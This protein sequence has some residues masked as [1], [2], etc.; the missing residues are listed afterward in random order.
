MS[1]TIS[2]KRAKWQ[3]TV[4]KLE[5]QLDKL[6]DAILAATTEY[7]QYKLETGEGSQSVKYRDLGKLIENQT[8]LQKQ[9]DW[10]NTKICGGGIRRFS[11][12]RRLY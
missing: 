4:T 7:E 5:A 8:I 10:Y 1:A 9:I 11:Q 3:A 2:Q 12:Q 6:N